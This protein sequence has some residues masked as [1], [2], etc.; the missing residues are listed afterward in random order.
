MTF[1]H[2]LEHDQ[3]QVAYIPYGFLALFTLNLMKEAECSSEI[4]ESIYKIQSDNP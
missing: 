1:T 4:V 3:V 2:I